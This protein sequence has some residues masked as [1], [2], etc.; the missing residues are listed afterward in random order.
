MSPAQSSPS[1]SCSD[2]TDSS[3]FRPK[4]RC[5]DIIK[6]L[7]RRR[8]H[9]VLQTIS[10]AVQ[11]EALAGNSEA[12]TFCAQLWN[13]RP[14][15]SSQISEI[16]GEDVKPMWE[17]F[18]ARLGHDI[19]RSKLFGEIPAM[20]DSSQGS[21][22]KAASSCRRIRPLP[23][24]SFP[25]SNPSVNSWQKSPNLSPWKITPSESTPTC[26]KSCLSDLP[27]NENDSE[28]MLL[29]GVL[30]EA[31]KSGWVPGHIQEVVVKAETEEIEKPTAQNLT[32]ELPRATRKKTGKQLRGVR[33][34]PWGKF[35]AE[36]RDSAKQ[37]RRTW[38]GTFNTAEEA[39]MAYDRAALRMRGP[40]A[41]LNFPMEIVV[42]T[43]DSHSQSITSRRKRERVNSEEEA[44]SPKEQRLA[45]ARDFLSLDYD[46]SSVQDCPVDDAFLVAGLLPSF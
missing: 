45:L 12:L 24:L 28:D 1:S 22:S 6:N 19:L 18:P 46:T 33:R 23:P 44:P 16:L 25:A 34:R 38:L 40:R 15:D 30:K 39:A 10:H 20:V 9:S 21:V 26:L 2:T 35:A 8:Q 37:G 14:S 13:P 43:L 32:T 42:S 31:T 5:I 36:I 4:I 27:L 11:S 7:G 29:Y 3:S 41:L 17:G